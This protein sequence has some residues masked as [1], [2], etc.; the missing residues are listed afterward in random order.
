MTQSIIQKEKQLTYSQKCIRCANCLLFIHLMKQ[1][2]MSR[3]LTLAYQKKK[4][5]L[6]NVRVRWKL[7]HKFIPAL[8]HI[9]RS[10]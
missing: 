4:K 7:T 8:H 5:K 2:L 9:L 3:V 1:F 6:S 10:P